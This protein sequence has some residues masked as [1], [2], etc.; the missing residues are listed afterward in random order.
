MDIKERA[1]NTDSKNIDLVFRENIT[2]REKFRKKLGQLCHLRPGH[3]NVS[4]EVPPSLLNSRASAAQA[5]ESRLTF[6][7]LSAFFSFRIPERHGQAFCVL[8]GVLDEITER[9]GK[10]FPFEYVFTD[11]Y[12]GKR[13]S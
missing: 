12:Y 13:V 9:R 5:F 3:G 6:L 2:G 10:R 11:S 1:E 7:C 8:F 4:N